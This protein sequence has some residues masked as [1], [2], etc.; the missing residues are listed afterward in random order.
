MF[1]MLEM[2]ETAEQ[3]RICPDK[4]AEE[5]SRRMAA[6]GIPTEHD[7]MT[8]VTKVKDFEPATP[9]ELACPPDC[10][11]SYTRPR[12]LFGGR[13]KLPAVFDVQVCPLKELAGR[14]EELFR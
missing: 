6:V 10:P 8:Y 1:R 2:P 3:L 4:Q 7:Y 14:R 5:D 9:E 13:I 11:G 12:T